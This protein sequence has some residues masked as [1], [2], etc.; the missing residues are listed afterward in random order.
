MATETAEPPA[1]PLTTPFSAALGKSFTEAAN[2]GKEPVVTEVKEKPPVEEVKPKEGTPK[3]LFKNP[4]AE[5]KSAFDD[6]AAPEFKDEKGR[7]GW[8]AQRA[9]GKKWEQ[10]AQALEKQISEWKAAG[11]DPEALEKKLAEKESKLTEYSDLVARA[12][13]ETH[14]EFKREF[15]DGREKLVNRAKTL[16]D[17]AGGDGA[18]VAKALNLTGKAREDAL[19]EHAEGLN[20]LQAGRLGNILDELSS[21]DERAEEKRSKAQES[22]AE[23]QERERLKQID[24]RAN[25]VK[26]RSLEFDD[27]VKQLR[28]Q[29]EVLNPAE[30]HDEWN[31][32]AE[33]IIQGARAYVEQNPTADIEAEIRARSMM[34]YRGLFIQADKAVEER[35]AEITKL[36]AELKAIHGKSPALNGR[37]SAAPSTGDS[38]RPFSAGLSKT[39]TGE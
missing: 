22:Y 3:D 4:D 34:A 11:R 16:I 28:G 37:G 24:E 19:T 30:G 12:R 8:E 32:R 31:K 35:D 33:E 17:A 25:L 5:P 20:Q 13:I 29:L 18:A 7:K 38:K 39:M 27:T 10:Q 23:I 1:K 26:R 36:K 2:A 9:E 21:L 6:I 15:I 14:P